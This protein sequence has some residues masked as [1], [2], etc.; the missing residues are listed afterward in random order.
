[1]LVIRDSLQNDIEKLR[2]EQRYMENDLSSLQMRWHSV[3][4]E[5][6]KVANQFAYIKSVQEELEHLEEEKSHLELEEKVSLALMLWVKMLS[7]G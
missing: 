2:D 5:K 6:L 4:E 1:L 7:P 3:R